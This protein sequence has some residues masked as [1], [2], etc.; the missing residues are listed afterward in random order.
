[1]GKPRPR[2]PH[3]P[4][5]PTRRPTISLCVIARNEAD[6]IGDC[7]ASAQPFVDELVVLDTGSIDATREI[8]RS[9]NARVGTFE[10]V[11]NFSAA[12]N[13]AIDLATSDWILMLDADERLQPESGPKLREFVQ[14]NPT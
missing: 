8:A 3:R 14:S 5:A 6:F 1:M 13:A 4:Y 9:Y 11:D 2:K 7:L 10:W 12:R